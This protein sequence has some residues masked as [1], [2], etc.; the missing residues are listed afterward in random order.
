[1]TDPQASAI[2]VSPLLPFP[3]A[4]GGQKRT[5]RL[6][7]AMQRAGARPRILTAHDAAPE[8]VAALR[9]RGCDVELLAFSPGLRVR[10]AQHLARR[11]SPYLAPVAARLRPGAAPPAAFLQLEHTMSAYYRGL[12]PGTPVV[13]SLHNLDSELAA[14]AA[15]SRRPGLARARDSNRAAAF[16]AQERGAFPQVDRVLCVSEHD[17]HAVA[18]LGG[19]PLL[20]PNGVDADLFAHPA[21]PARE[22]L[23]AFFGH[24]GYRPNRDG[25]LRFLREGWARTLVARP[26]ARLAVAGPGIDDAV[27]A[28][29]EAFPG[30]DVLGLVPDLAALLTR[31]AAVLVPLWEGGGTRL[32][33]LE[34]M[35]AARPVVGTPL[36]IERI[37]FAPGEHGLVAPDPAGLADAL[38]SLLAD[39]PRAAALGGQARAHAER[40][41]WER[42]TAELEEL[43]ATY[44]AAAA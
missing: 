31:S 40:F 17:A 18:A 30:V 21:A 24:F 8:D 26:R 29:L 9:D 44:V 3:P 11:P 35:A 14:A 37:G 1:V 10:V 43:Y 7:E 15:H 25:L 23:A 36:G 28:E 33:A 6:V 16:A 12:R 13:L 38:A 4:S 2:V 5:L 27:R 32:K 39:L 20:V 42:V 22:E 41:R 34:A 19:T